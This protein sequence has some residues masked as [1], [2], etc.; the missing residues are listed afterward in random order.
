MY[1]KCLKL[2]KVMTMKNLS[3]KSLCSTSL[4]LVNYIMYLKLK[5]GFNQ[6]LLEQGDLNWKWVS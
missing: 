1:S 6:E 2:K 3:L 4:L 5:K